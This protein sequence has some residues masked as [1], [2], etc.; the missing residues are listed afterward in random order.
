MALLGVLFALAAGLHAAP[1]RFTPVRPAP[2]P[3]TLSCPISASRIFLPAS[4]KP[5]LPSPSPLPAPRVLPAPQTASGPDQAPTGILEVLS[6]KVSAADL[7]KPGAEEDLTREL[8]G[9]TLPEG[10]PVYPGLVALDG[11]AQKDLQLSRSKTMLAAAVHAALPALEKSVALGGWNGPG[12]NLDKPCCGDAAPKLAYLLRAHGM[13][14]NVVEAEFHYYLSQ[15]LEHGRLF[16]DPTIRQFFGG[17][18]APPEIPKVFVGN[19]SDLHA[20]FRRHAGAKTTSYG[21]ERI[22]F[23][24]AR[25]R[26]ERRQAVAAAADPGPEHRA[27]APIAAVQ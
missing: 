22:Y 1:G 6:A 10:E 27:L 14:V 11:L 12:T 4:M 3:L 8:Y 23:N 21:V 19:L 13:A 26:N 9:E 20:L 18:R 2:A 16:V 24:A 25:V 7:S 5:S 15:D 17:S